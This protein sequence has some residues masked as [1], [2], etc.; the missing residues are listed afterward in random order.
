MDKKEIDKY[1]SELTRL[2]SRSLTIMST[3]KMEYYL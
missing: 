2:F 3:P 1:A